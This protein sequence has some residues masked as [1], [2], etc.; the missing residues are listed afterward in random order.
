[1]S[2]V[3]SAWAL[4]TGFYLATLLA[5]LVL[6]VP[7]IKDHMAQEQA[8]RSGRAAAAAAAIFANVVADDPRPLRSYATL[9]RDGAEAGGWTRFEIKDNTG[10]VVLPA[11]VSKPSWADALAGGW[12]AASAS[13]ALGRPGQAAGVVKVWVS[14]DAASEVLQHCLLAV[15]GA[16]AFIGA[17][18]VAALAWMVRWAR[19]PLDD[20]NELVQGLSERRFVALKEPKIAEWIELSRSLNVMVARVRDMLQARDSAVN[21]LEAKLAVDQMTQTASRPQF[22]QEL[23]TRLKERPEG[24][25]AV[26]VRVHDLDG[27]NRRVGRSR[28]DDFLVAVATTLRT[29]LLMAGLGEEATLARLNG[30]DFAM[31]LT[32][33][34]DGQVRDR[35]EHLSQSLAALAEDGLSES[36]QVAWI[37]ATAFTQG[38]ASSAVL[39]RLDAMLMKAESDL[40]PM[41]LADPVA[42]PYVITV[43]Q[44]RVLIETALDTGRFTL[45]FFPFCDSQGQLIHR[46]AMARLVD[47]EGRWLE[48]NEIVPPAI[49]NGRIAEVD[50]RVLE[51]AL[52]ELGQCEGALAV[53]VAAQSLRRP[54]FLMRLGQLLER[55]AAVAGRLCLEVDER[56]FDAASLSSAQALCRTVA[57]HGCRVGIDHFGLTLSMLPLLSAVHVHYVKLAPALLKALDQNTRLQA[58]VGQ[59]TLLGHRVGV[60][61][62]ANGV[63]MASDLPMLKSLGVQ[64][65]GGPAVAEVG[66]AQPVVTI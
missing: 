59:L 24:G 56:G 45:A 44:W 26:I 17:L 49:R 5:C 12:P 16:F 15:V 20:F 31:L 36:L 46:E 64:G 62:M 33:Q 39:M 53:N 19:A 42:A 66:A 3:R 43:T 63:T 7:P 51:L 55:Y 8:V 11:A 37:G 10:T 35:L 14:A 23:A 38:E 47:S 27:M 34:E 48:A 52:V 21:D 41:C 4:I 22:M 18:M 25:C 13:A 61:V 2:I 28:A 1:M 29:R 50:L 9:L 6:V 40:Q 57:P 60:P 58:F 54:M 65:F 32:A 30:A